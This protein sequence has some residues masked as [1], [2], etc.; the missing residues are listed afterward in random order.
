MWA[1][2]NIAISIKKYSKLDV[3]FEIVFRDASK[4]L[5]DYADADLIWASY[6]HVSSDLINIGLKNICVTIQEPAMWDNG[7]SFPPFVEDPSDWVID[8]CNKN[9]GVSAPNKLIYDLLSK[10]IENE[11][12][13]YTRLAADPDFF[14]MSQ[15]IKDSAKMTIGFCGNKDAERKRYDIYEDIKE[16]LGDQYLWLERTQL[17]AGQ[18]YDVIQQFFNR[19]DIL[20]I[21]SRVEGGPLPLIEAAMC[22]RVVISS[23]V[24]LAPEFIDHEKNGFLI[25]LDTEDYIETLTKILDGKYDLHSISLEARKTALG[26]FSWPTVIDQWDNFF[27]DS[28]NKR[29][30]N[31]NQ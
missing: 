11:K 27:R 10:R 7:K 18:Q 6:K 8:I 2:H 15:P 5:A 26:K 21:T 13:F 24:G 3:E 17:N 28:L 4:T 16:G 25:D 1:L 14:R 22:G 31:G 9:L 29:S 12:L 19:I 30:D 23:K 20:V